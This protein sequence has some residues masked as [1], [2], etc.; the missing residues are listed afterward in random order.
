MHERSNLQKLN[1]PSA[2][3]M[4]VAVTTS[5]FLGSM[6]VHAIAADDAIAKADN[7]A[8]LSEEQQRIA[9]K[10]K[11]LE[12]VL[13]RMAELTASTDPQRAELLR[14]TVA[15]SK[16]RLIGVQF[17]KIIDLLDRQ[18]LSRAIEG[19]RDLEKDLVQ[20]LELLLSEDRAKRIASDKARIRQYLKQLNHIIRKQKVLEGRTEGKGDASQLAQE[21]DQ[22]GDKTG[23]LSNQMKSDDE[24]G[25]SGSGE[26]SG[27]KAD[28]KS[29]DKSES[30]KDIIPSDSKSGGAGGKSKN[31]QPQQQQQ[32]S[33]TDNP[34]RKSLEAARKKMKEAQE[35]LEKVKHDGAVEKQEE[36]LRQLEQAKAELEKILRQ[37]REE[38]MKRMLTALAARFAKMLILQREVYKGTTLLDKVPAQQRGHEHEIGAG[39]LAGKQSIITTEADKVLLL[40]KEDG[41]AVAF[42]EAV[43]QMRDDMQQTA[44]RLGKN[45]VDKITQGL[46]EDILAALEEM[47]E[48]LKKE[49]EKLEEQQ[50]QQS[51]QSGKK[52]D[53]ELIET[54]AELKMIRALQMRVNRRTIR[55]GKL[56]DGEEARNPELRE[57]LRRLAQREERIHEVTRKLD[58]EK[59]K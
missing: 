37:L 36:A 29:G 19:Q 1:L 32:Q 21:Q 26:K 56:I 12:D 51:Q 41:T 20:L 59:G 10:Y 42:P 52:Q 33:E 55:Y 44:E 22:L 49:I 17:E 50:S 23:R 27:D 53:P 5:L 2:L 30:S 40:L 57:A 28:A 35:S 38:E 46:E 48:A 9:D 31:Q 6:C 25:K 3:L 58:L 34:A 47:I 18:R 14:K 4:T 54:L 45:L 16:Q 11:H 8:Q 7:P 13:L 15:Q 39:R 24:M 43:S